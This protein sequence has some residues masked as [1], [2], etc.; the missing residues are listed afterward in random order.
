MNRVI[1]GVLMAV[2]WFLLL[3]M[4]TPFLFW[5][6][7]LLGAGIALHEFFR[8]ACSFLTG[9]R[10]YGTILACLFPVLS[11]F[12][13]QIEL[14]PVGLFISLLALVTLSLQAYGKVDDVFR[15]LTCGGFAALY[16]SG[17]LA[18]LVLIRFLPQGPYWL[19]L[20]IAMVAGSDT[21]AY[22]AGK[23]FGRRKLFPLI[24][25]KKTVAGG[26]GGI[27]T[28][29]VAAESIN[30]L[31][32]QPA[33]P[34]LLLLASSL[35]IVIGISGDLAESLIKRSVGVKDSGTVLF[36]H[37]GLLDRVDSLLLTGPVFFYLLYFKLLQ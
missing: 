8:M 34:V 18:H 29:V 19:A 6:V 3:F 1:P 4:G 12:N 2:C 31:L 13:G 24:S 9:L 26:I 15:Y 10:L 35:M 37:G 5:C 25:P 30:R 28:G 21:G 17:C 36:G 14:V 22:Y 20:F 11:V 7:G 23:T 33:D 27:L 16:I 32:P